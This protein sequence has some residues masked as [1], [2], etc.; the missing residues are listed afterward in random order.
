M[1]GKVFKKMPHSVWRIPNSVWRISF[2]KDVMFKLDKEQG[3][4]IFGMA[5]N[6]CKGT[7]AGEN[8]ELNLPLIGSLSSL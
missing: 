4:I 1:F 8:M 2:P 6:M 3:E 7:E 5:D